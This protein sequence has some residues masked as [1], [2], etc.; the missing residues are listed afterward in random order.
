MNQALIDYECAR[1]NKR[2]A[3]LSEAITVDEDVVRYLR[4]MHEDP[5]DFEEF[6]DAVLEDDEVNTPMVVLGIG[7]V[8][9]K[10]LGEL[11][12]EGVMYKLLLK[13]NDC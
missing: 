6:V 7:A 3:A 13:Y 5:N 8:L 12:E 10:A 9:Y 2:I 11:D 4:L 1:L